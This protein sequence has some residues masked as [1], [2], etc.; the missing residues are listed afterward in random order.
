[1]KKLLVYGSLREGDYN[2][3]RIKSYFGEDSIK[4]IG[5][6]TLTGYSIFN[7]GSY[8]GLNKTNN[9]E[10]SVLF[11]IVEVK[12]NAYEFIQGMELGAGYTEEKLDDYI[13]YVY[14]HKFDEKDRIISGDWLKFKKERK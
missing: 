7:L 14:D 8:P 5:E 9:E 13:F 11:D 10:H 2:F 1:M 6:K 12:D 3:D 4:K